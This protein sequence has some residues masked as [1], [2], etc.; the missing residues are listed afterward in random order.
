MQAAMGMLVGSITG[1]TRH[2]EMNSPAWKM[3]TVAA[4]EKSEELVEED[5][6]KVIEMLMASSNIATIYL[7]IKNPCTSSLFL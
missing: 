4:I 5:F 1:I 2:S 6:T 3:A 7:A